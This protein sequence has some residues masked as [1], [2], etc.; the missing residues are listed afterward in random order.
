MINN[1]LGM[2]TIADPIESFDFINIFEDIF[3]VDPSTLT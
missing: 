2:M 3:H 1:F